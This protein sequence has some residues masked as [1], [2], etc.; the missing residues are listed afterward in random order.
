MKLIATKLF[1]LAV[2]AFL[3]LTSNY[4]FAQGVTTAAIHGTITDENGNVLPSANV[5]AVHIPTGTQYGT[6]T[7][8]DGKYNILGLR[9]GGPYTITVSFVGYE[10]QKKEDVYLNLGQNLNLSFKLNTSAVNLSQVTIV[11]QRNA[12]IS[13]ARTGAFQSVSSKQ[14]QEIPTISR[15][16]QNFAKLSPLFSGTNM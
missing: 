12:I 2:V 9:V 1:T 3:L 7:R 5:V 6:T 14:M 4:M 16:F 13:S 8:N 11:G 10:T 15:S